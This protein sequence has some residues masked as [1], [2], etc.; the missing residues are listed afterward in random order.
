[1]VILLKLYEIKFKSE[2]LIL[3][4]NKTSLINLIADTKYLHA[5]LIYHWESI[6]KINILVFKLLIFKR[7]YLK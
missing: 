4:Y 1:M 2:N 7:Y 3:T 5:S 6:T